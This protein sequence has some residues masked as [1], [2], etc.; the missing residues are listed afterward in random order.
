MGVKRSLRSSSSKATEPSTLKSNRPLLGGE[1]SP[2][3]EEKWI[4]PPFF[5][6]YLFD[7]S[8]DWEF[9]SCSTN[10]LYTACG[11]PNDLLTTDVELKHIPRLDTCKGDFAP[12]ID[13][14]FKSHTPLCKGWRSW[15]RRVLIHPPFMDIL[16]GVHLMHTAWC[17]L[18]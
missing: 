16:Q 8:F 6:D 15:C 13:V 3:I 9:V 5:E 12:T 1:E 2:P 18:A 11:E 10:P 4:I 17:F 14:V 7:K